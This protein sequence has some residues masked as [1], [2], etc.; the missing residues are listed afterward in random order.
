MLTWSSENWAAALW[1]RPPIHANEASKSPPPDERG[2]LRET[3]SA[4]TPARSRSL[5]STV[6]S[7]P[8]PFPFSSSNCVAPTRSCR[9]SN[10]GST[11]VPPR[12]SRC[13]SLRTLRRLISKGSSCSSVGRIRFSS[14][15][16]A[17]TSMSARPSASA[18]CMIGRSRAAIPWIHHSPFG[19]CRSSMLVSRITTRLTT[20]VL[21][22][23]RRVRAIP[24]LT[25]SAAMTRDSGAPRVS[26]AS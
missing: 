16:S 24:M 1:T 5:A 3:S 11:I 2:Q 25:C 7:Q 15:S 18:G 4:A 17:M 12:V 26:S 6:T 9:P 20:S 21:S 19:S 14:T 8:P 22:A 10:S 13:S 23:S